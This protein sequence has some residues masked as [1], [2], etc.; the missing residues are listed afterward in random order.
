MASSKLILPEGYRPGLDI[1]ETERAIKLVKDNFQKQ[2][3]D[4]LNLTRVSAPLF[5]RPETGLNDDLNG[6][7]RRS[8]SISSIS[9]PTSRSSTPSQ[10]GSA[11]PSSGTAFRRGP[12]C[13][14]I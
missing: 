3:A 7:E 1:L 12:D 5:V 6:V 14:P 4:Q 2:L 8:S 11:L 10:N 9:A 13:T